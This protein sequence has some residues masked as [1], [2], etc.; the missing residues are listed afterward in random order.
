MQIFLPKQEFETFQA[1]DFDSFVD[2]AVGLLNKYKDT[3]KV[4][5]QLIPDSD[6]KYATFGNFPN[7]IEKYTEGQPCTLSFSA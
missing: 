7:Y 5:L 1:P 2:R 6:L 3:A 4:N